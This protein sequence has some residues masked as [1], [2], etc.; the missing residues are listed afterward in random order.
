MPLQTLH[1]LLKHTPHRTPAH[2]DSHILAIRLI[3]RPRDL[4]I[5]HTHTTNY[6]P[7]PDE[8]ESHAQRRRQAHDFDNDV[9]ATAV[10]ELFD[11]CI[12]AGAVG[13]EVP[14]LGAEGFGE[15][16]ARGDRIHCKDGLWVEVGE[17]AEGAESDGAAADEDDDAFLDF[18]GSGMFEAILSREHAC[19][20]YR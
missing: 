3:S 6:A 9:G 14:W 4:R 12:E 10:G 16:E 15:L 7:R 1:R 17:V 8:L 5:M 11:P 19:T 20:W 18:F 2:L 13:L